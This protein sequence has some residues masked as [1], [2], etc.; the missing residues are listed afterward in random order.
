MLTGLI[1]NGQAIPPLGDAPVTLEVDPNGGRISGTTGCNL[2]RAILNSDANG[3][4][5]M[6]PALMTQKACAANLMVQE[7]EFIDSLLRTHSY[8][9]SGTELTLLDTGGQT[10]LVFAKK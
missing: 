7:V 4:T 3:A 5:I 2:Y 6:G 8:T 1:A 9:V 10:L